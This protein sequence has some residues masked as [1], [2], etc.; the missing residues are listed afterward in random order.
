MSFHQRS[1]LRPLNASLLDDLLAAFDAL[2]K[3]AVFKL[4]TD[5]VKRV[6]ARL[7]NPERD[8]PPV[9]HVAGTNGK[10]STIA[11]MRAIAEAHGLKAHIDTSPHLIRVNERIRVAGELISDADLRRH[12]NT[13]LDANSGEPLSFFEGMTIASFLAFAETHADLTI[14]EVGLGGRFDSTNVF[15][16]PA[17]SVI[18]PIAMDHKELLGPNLTNIAWEKAGIIKPNTPVVSAKQQRAA[19][20][21]LRI[22]AKHCGTALHYVDA[23]CQVTEDNG[24]TQ[25]NLNGLKIETKRLGLLGPHQTE[26]AA[27]A[28]SA[29]RTANIFD[30]DPDKTAIGLRS[31]SWPA[32]LQTLKS[33]PLTQAMGV[34]TVILD[35]G[36]NP[37]A[38]R[39]I[40]AALEDKAPV[41]IIIGMLHNKDARQFLEIIAPI[42]EAV[43]T[44]PLPD[45]KRGFVPEDLAAIAA[46]LG[47]PS[48]ACSSLDVAAKHIAT[49]AQNAA[50]ICGSL[51]IAGD[52]LEKNGEFV[53]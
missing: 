28:L 52:V 53:T 35:G 18:T 3:P 33:G 4:S 23:L 43:Y 7:G 40:K 51:Y 31:V 9:I 14:I 15:D 10:G 5:P 41:P 34:K 21:T 39:A 36:H 46:E 17:V 6:L 1:E 32:R 12:V 49:S 47:L 30:L 38:A 20:E 29:L 8:L 26:N 24:L 13:V 45:D 22:Q 11:F 50:L 44:I 48:T 25:F 37:H 42:I 27:L 2:P 16:A 19:A